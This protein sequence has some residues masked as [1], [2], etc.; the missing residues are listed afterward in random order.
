MMSVH[1]SL[2]IQE[3]HDV[4]ACEG[5]FNEQRTKLAHVAS[6]RRSDVTVLVHLTLVSLHSR[7]LHAVRAGEQAA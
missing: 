6:E 2:V 1:E 5:T 7:K 4:L 3:T